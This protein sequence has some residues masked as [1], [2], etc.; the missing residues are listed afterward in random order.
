M[1]WSSFHSFIIL[2][3]Q[4]QRLHQIALETTEGSP[5]TAEEGV[6]Q[7]ANDDVIQNEA[8]AQL[9]SPPSYNSLKVIAH[10]T[11]HD[12]FDECIEKSKN[13]TLPPSYSC[14]MLHQ[15][16]FHLS[17]TDLSKIKLSNMQKVS[18]SDSDVHTARS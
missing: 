15:D 5:I 8:A 7:N 6:E 4:R 2:C 9:F 10:E 13:S 12:D 16:K 1:F 17:Y 11:R 14:V 18:L 3:L